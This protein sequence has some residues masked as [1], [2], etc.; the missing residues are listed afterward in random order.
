MVYYFLYNTIKGGFKMSTNTLNSLNT[1]E[2]EDEEYITLPA[3]VFA[4]G[5]RIV[6]TTTF[7]FGL[8]HAHLK[9]SDYSDE[10]E[11]PLTVSKIL[12]LENRNLKRQSVKELVQYMK[13]NK[14]NYILPS[15]TLNSEEFLSITPISPTLEELNT[16]YGEEISNIQLRYDLI[17]I[18]NKVGGRIGVELKI[19]QSF[20]NA[21]EGLKPI[22]TVLD[23]NHRS[24]SA[25]ILVEE[26]PDYW[27]NAQIGVTIFLEPDKSQRKKHFVLLNSSTPVQSSVKGLFM[28]DD[29]LSEAVKHLTGL[30]LDGYRFIIKQL[31]DRDHTK[32]I[33]FEPVDNVGANS[34]NILSFNILRNMISIMGTNTTS[35]KTFQK[36]YSTQTPEEIDIY[37][38]L[39]SDCKEYFEH[40]FDLVEPFKLVQ[41]HLDQIPEYKK[42]YLSLSGA[43]LYVI[44]HVGYESLEKGYNLK[45]IA[46]IL[47]EL[48]WR[49]Q[50]LIHDE[51][52]ANPFFNGTILSN[53]GGISNTRTA[54]KPAVDKVMEYIDNRIPVI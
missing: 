36:K 46:T 11:E 14:H 5:D 6:Y 54:I 9:T 40:V 44:S 53:D 8:I 13:D 39:L 45:Q 48:D 37:R 29:I 52:T 26:S 18:L 4:Q 47:A 43:G 1:L 41:G 17:N 16:L 15:I 50:V 34:K 27:T 28:V 30:R 49:K 20:F 35:S 38:Q 32:N 22:I 42:N 24:E 7:S 23:G 10:I 33:G 51:P 19:P 25:K 21:Q 31:N 2:I 12:E 3:V